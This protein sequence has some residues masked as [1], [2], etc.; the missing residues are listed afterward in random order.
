MQTGLNDL[1]NRALL[2]HETPIDVLTTPVVSIG[3]HRAVTAP[4]HRVRYLRVMR[5]IQTVVERTV[6]VFALAVLGLP[7][8]VVGL[9]IRLNSPG[10]A[11]FV[12]DRVGLNGRLFRFY[13]FRT[14]VHGADDLLEYVIDLNEH[15]GV[16]FKVKNDPRCT[17]LGKRL[18]RYSI[19]EFP[20]LINVALGHM[21]FVGPRP[22]L[23]GEVTQYGSDARRRL[24]VKPGITGL[25]QVSG[26]SNLSWDESVR[27]DL[28]YVDD[29]SPLLDVKIL[30]RTIPAV[31]SSHGAY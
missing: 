3:D 26:R 17:T 9:M 18:R 12:Q 22:P 28:E 27:L 4:L 1:S 16:L 20:Q 30:L 8:L 19:D 21:S 23:P 2:D 11:F 15:D 24:L 13:K 10:P 14:M 25:W 5:V 6:A 31:L 29:W 7:F